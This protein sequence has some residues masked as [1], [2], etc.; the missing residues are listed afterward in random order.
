[1]MMPP[2]DLEMAPPFSTLFPVRQ[3]VLRALVE[4]MKTKG[5]DMAQPVVI[6][7]KPG[8]KPRVVDGRTR[9]LAA[10]EAGIEVAVYVAEF[11]DPGDEEAVDRA[12]EYAI[13]RQRDRRNLTDAEVI[14]CLSVLDERKKAGRQPVI[15]PNQKL[16][17]IDANLPADKPAAGKSAARMAETLG[18]DTSKVER[19]RKILK[20]APDEIKA[21]VVAGEATIHSAWKETRNRSKSGTTSAPIVTKSTTAPPEIK[22]AVASV[23]LPKEGQPLTDAEREFFGRIPLRNELAGDDA[24]SPMDN[25]LRLF[26]MLEGRLKQ[27]REDVLNLLGPCSKEWLGP[28]HQA[29]S[30]L[31][32]I[33]PPTLWDRCRKC[34]G[35]RIVLGEGTCKRCRGLGY[36]T[37]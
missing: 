22:R 4:N 18:V 20:D 26:L 12:L 28:F 13:S 34:D 11:G 27:M 35:Q 16:A 24:A 31:I 8:S 17:S 2:E 36:S 25:D 10:T 5:Y 21:K 7:A 30:N 33:P 23:P 15:G 14:Q 19:A 29:V 37:N 1:M 32:S 6:W 9:V 3:D